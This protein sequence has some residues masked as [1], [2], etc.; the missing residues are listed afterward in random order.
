MNL[1][2]LRLSPHSLNRPE[3]LGD[4]GRVS[5]ID[6]EYKFHWTSHNLPAASEQL[7]LML[8][9]IPKGP[10]FN[11]NPMPTRQALDC[12]GRTLQAPRHALA[13][14]NRI[15][16]MCPSITSDSHSDAGMVLACGQQP[17]S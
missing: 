3:H 8:Q 15:A 5:S 4:P 12:R 14:T 16:T 2:A 13:I 17:S 6:G 9:H 1:W 11:A 7:L 10:T